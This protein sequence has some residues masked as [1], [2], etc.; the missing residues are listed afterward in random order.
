MK[1]KLKEAILEIYIRGFEYGTYAA[2][3]CAESCRDDRYADIK[4]II[5]KWATY[6]KVTQKYLFKEFQKGEAAGIIAW[7]NEVDKLRERLSY[8]SVSIIN[9]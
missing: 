2:C 3:Y 7:T 6:A 9:D 1:E 8:P 5:K 4:P